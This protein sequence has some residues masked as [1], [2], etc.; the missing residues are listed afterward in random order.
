MVLAAEGIEGRVAL[1][2]HDRL[3]VV[4]PPRPAPAAAVA[5]EGRLLSTPEGRHAAADDAYVRTPETGAFESSGRAL[6]QPI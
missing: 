4:L 5:P 3:D 2:T 6:P 1:R